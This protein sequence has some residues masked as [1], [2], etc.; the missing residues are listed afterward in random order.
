MSKYILFNQCKLQEC[1]YLVV[2]AQM[3]AKVNSI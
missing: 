1:Q 2:L 3:K